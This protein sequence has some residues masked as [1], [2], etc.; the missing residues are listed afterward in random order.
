MARWRLAVVAYT[1]ACLTLTLI[2]LAW[3]EAIG[4]IK[5]LS[6]EV[7]RVR[8]N[9]KSPAQAGDLVEKADTLMTGPD[10]RIGITF[11]DDTRFSIGPNSS[12]ALEKFA[13]NPTTKDGE[14]L[15]KVE[16]GTLAVISGDIAHSSPD[17]MKV[18]TRKVVLGMRGTYLFVQVK[19]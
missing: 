19:E 4:Q 12:I 9:V 15:A 16:R 7:F 2:P 10:G 14:F 3:A 8:D 13:F 1:V 6:G 11:I 18:Q 17:A 5:K